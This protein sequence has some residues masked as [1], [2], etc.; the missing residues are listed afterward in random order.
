VHKKLE[1][2]DC[3]RLKPGSQDRASQINLRSLEAE[4]LG[5]SS[6]LEF[7]E[8]ISSNQ[9]SWDILKGIS[10]FGEQAFKANR[11]HSAVIKTE[12]ISSYETGTQESLQI[13]STGGSLVAPMSLEMSMLEESLLME[14]MLGENQYPVA[15][16]PP[17]LTGGVGVKNLPPKP[18][19]KLIVKSNDTTKEQVCSLNDIEWNLNEFEPNNELIQENI[20]ILGVD[21]FPG[22]KLEELTQASNQAIN[23]ETTFQ[24]QEL[25]LPVV[26][27]TGEVQPTIIYMTAS[28]PVVDQWSA[29]SLF[30]DLQNQDEDLTAHNPLEVTGQVQ[31]KP[32][33][34]ENI[35]ATSFAKPGEMDLLATLMNDEIGA[36]SEEFKKFVEVE[37][38]V[39]ESTI[40]FGALYGPSTSTASASFEVK[41]EPMEVV[42]FVPEEVNETPVKRGRGRPRVPRTQPEAPRRPRGRPPTAAT[43]ANIQDYESSSN[44]SSEELQ[45]VRYR[46]MR[47]L[48]NAASKRCRVNR[49][50]KT[51]A[52]ETEEILE[53]ARNIELKNTVK[54]LESQVAQ[55]KTAI[56]DLI[57]KR[58]IEKTLEAT[59]TSVSGASTSTGSSATSGTSQPE[60]AVMS[61]DLDMF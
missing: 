16:H 60:M 14:G 61:F 15:S 9:R 53:A 29:N 49:K 31:V 21:P 41:D 6:S 11:I 51:E 1:F 47:D 48:N 46:R 56:F 38:N 58:K 25:N 17:I 44:M 8:A 39:P 13:C 59:S 19:K 23:T 7:Q 10:Y 57:K 27:V 30:P 33:E 20:Q 3:P 55:F 40:D 34:V 52:Q 36:D 42:T 26:Q 50:R 37:P 2:I 35:D 18:G 43:F 12:N 22:L 24:V 28:D 54:D 5:L 32:E 45:D 4:K